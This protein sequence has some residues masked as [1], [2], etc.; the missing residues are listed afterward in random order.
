[1][2]WA[3]AE[4]LEMITEKKIKTFVEQNIANKF[5]IPLGIALPGSLCTT[6]TRIEDLLPQ[7][8]GIHLIYVV[9]EKKKNQHNLLKF[10]Q[11]NRCEN[12]R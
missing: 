10:K 2:K 4:L 1:M 9:F 3:E 12:Q 8:S 7:G 11:T 6:L 5:G